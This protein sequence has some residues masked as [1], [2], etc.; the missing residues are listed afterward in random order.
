MKKHIKLSLLFAIL[1]AIMALNSCNVNCIKGSGRQVTEDRNIGNFTKV[2]FG[3]AMKLKI[4]QDSSSFMRITADDNIQREIKTRISGDVLKIEM[5]GNFCN[6]GE[7]II[8]LSS[9]QWKGIKASGSTQIMSENQINSNKFELDLSGA[10]TVNLDLVTGIFRAESSGSSEIN[11][12]GQARQCDISL[13]GSSEINAF[14]FVVSNYNIESS[15]SSKC[16]IN[17]L[18]SL[19][20][21]SSGSSKVIYKGNPKDIVNDKS[22]SST[23]KHVE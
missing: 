7:I 21:N 16:A 6:S 15:G 9:K 13:S 18:N 19:K 8:E 1:P 14:N 17:V 23:L 2:E 20:I 5:D 10:S 22:G 12:K 3:G 4:R 11:L